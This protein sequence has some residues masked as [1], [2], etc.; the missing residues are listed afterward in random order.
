MYG[1]PAAYPGC[2]ESGC[3][4]AIREGL[5]MAFPPD[6]LQP[7]DIRAFKLGMIYAFTEAVAS[8]CKP[9]ALSLSPGYG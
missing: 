3:L 6:Y 8:G 2:E 1:S 7:L 5:N 9:L 4:T